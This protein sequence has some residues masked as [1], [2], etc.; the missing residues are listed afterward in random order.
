MILD[1]PWS[2]RYCLRI[3]PIQKVVETEIQEIEKYAVTEISNQIT[4]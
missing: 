2:I 1:E 3:I 4:E